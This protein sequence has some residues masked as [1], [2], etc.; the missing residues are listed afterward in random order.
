MVDVAAIVMSLLRRLGELA[1]TPWT[2]PTTRITG[3]HCKIIPRENRT[4]CRRRRVILLT[5]WWPSVCRLLV[6]D[7]ALTST[8]ATSLRRR[9]SFLDLK[10]Q[11]RCV[12][13]LLVR[14]MM[15]GT[16][17]LLATTIKI[18]IMAGLTRLIQ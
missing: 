13:R 3:C 1:T 9:S 4:F 16:L 11:T 5:R 17:Q 14:H 12:L 6:P 7:R 8:D 2:D 10:L 18:L 15:E